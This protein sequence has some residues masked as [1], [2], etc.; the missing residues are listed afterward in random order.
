MVKTFID[1]CK[2]L[3]LK[4]IGPWDIIFSVIIVCI[5]TFKPFYAYG[6][7]N[8]FEMG[9]YLPSIEATLQGQIPYKDFFYLRGP[10]EIYIPALMM[11]FGGEHSGYLSLYFYL[12][13]VLCL[14]IACLI[15]AEVLKTRL[16]FYAFVPALVARAFPRVVFAYWGGVRYVWGLLFVY[17]LMWAFKT[18]RL[19]LFLLSGILAICA[20]MTSIE[21][22][23]SCFLASVGVFFIALFVQKRIGQSYGRALVM[24]IL[25][26]VVGF[27]PLLIYLVSVQAFIPFLES[28]EA[29]VFRSHPTFMTHLTSSSP[30]SLVEFLGA[31]VPGVKNFKYMTVLYC[32]LLTLGVLLWRYQQKRFS[33]FELGLACIWFYGI[34]LYFTAFRIIEGGLFETAL[35]LEKS[36]YF[37]LIEIFGLWLL[38]HRK[39]FK[40]FAIIFLVLVLVSS[41]GYAIT[42]YKK[43]FVIYDDKQLVALNIDRAKGIKTS[44]IQATE[45]ESVSKIVHQYTTREEKIFVYPDMGSYYFFLER[46]FV[47]RF[48]IA[49]LSWMRP[50]WHDELMQNF[51]AQKPKL[52]IVK[53]PLEHDFEHVYFKRKSNREYHETMMR[54]IDSHYKLIGNTPLSKV[55]LRK[56]LKI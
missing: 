38:F 48:P 21:I 12:G 53:F 36:L 15:A 41:W 14:I 31:M 54:Y 40:K 52:V 55:Y 29:V 1:R 28:V 35:Q 46:D 42:R 13:N 32:Y 27:I 7:L 47:G 16:M 37:F 6:P 45:L 24:H 3:A 39:Q 18:G 51:K 2:V 30:K 23:V 56:D 50:Q 17:V 34:V 20:A 26:Y 25:G 43:R 9:L 49:I 22:G 44:V 19:G 4:P 8:I 10:L 33:T 11:K 5:F